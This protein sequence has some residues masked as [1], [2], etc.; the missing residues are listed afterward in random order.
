MDIRSPLYKTSVLLLM[1]PMAD[2]VDAIDRLLLNPVIR[3]IPSLNPRPFLF[4]FSEIMDGVI[5]CEDDSRDLYVTEDW[6]A[7]RWYEEAHDVGPVD[8][9]RPEL[10]LFRSELMVMADNE[11]ARQSI[12]AEG[13]GSTIPR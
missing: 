9:D 1:L 2:G 4:S 5:D 8:W 12:A 11:D 6:V 13:S 3:L 7:G 10:R